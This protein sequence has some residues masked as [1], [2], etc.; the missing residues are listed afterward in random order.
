MRPIQNNPKRA[1]GRGRKP[2]GSGGGGPGNG[3]GRIGSGANPNRTLDSNGPDIKIRGTVSHIYEKYQTL[4]RDAISSGDYVGAENYLQ[5]AEHYFRVLAASAPV[6]SS[7]DSQPVMEGVNGAR[8][9]EA[10]QASGQ[11]EPENEAAQPQR[12]R[13]DAGGPR[14]ADA[15]HDKG[16]L[17]SA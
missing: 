2:H 15:D 12:G 6:Q 4:A 3:G 8:H 14:H 5:H 7:R 1:R 11:D 17:T 16:E 9:P 10:P 13:S